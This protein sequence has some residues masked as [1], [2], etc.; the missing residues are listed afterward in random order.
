MCQR[1]KLP[2]LTGYTEFFCTVR[3]PHVLLTTVQPR[4]NLTVMLRQQVHRAGNIG[5]NRSLSSDGWGG[6]DRTSEWRNQNPLPYRLATPHPRVR[7]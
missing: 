5:R 2:K 4:L 6:R 7:A 3:H 1:P